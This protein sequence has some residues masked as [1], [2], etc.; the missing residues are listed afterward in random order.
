MANFAGL[1][2]YEL[3]GQVTLYGRSWRSVDIST[4]AR[5]MPRKQQ[6]RTYP[7]E[8]LLIHVASIEDLRNVVV[9]G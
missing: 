2:A 9:S 1:S 4:Y 8:A 5:N 6:I 7:D 3:F